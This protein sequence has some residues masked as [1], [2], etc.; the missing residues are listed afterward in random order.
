MV[1][2][3]ESLLFAPLVFG[4][5]HVAGDLFLLVVREESS[6]GGVFWRSLLEESSGG[7][8]WRSLLEESSGGPLLCF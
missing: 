2:P 7:V 4:I 1:W 6:G 8:F 5:P 3:A